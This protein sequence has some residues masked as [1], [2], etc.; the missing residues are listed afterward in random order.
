MPR[1]RR[2]YTPEFKA[3]VVKL[4][5]DHAESK[6]RYGS[7]R[8]HAELVAHGHNCC[9]NTVAK[10]M[11]EAGMPRKPRGSFAAPRTPT[12]TY[13][14]RKISWTA[15]S[16]PLP[17]TS[18]GLPSLCDR[19]PEDFRRQHDLTNDRAEGQDRHPH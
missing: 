12:T 14:W 7:P 5:T 6:A 4:V 3:E 8:I 18:L 15:S 10:L 16:I 19:G 11:R 17:P 1:I 9:V 13:P 2:T